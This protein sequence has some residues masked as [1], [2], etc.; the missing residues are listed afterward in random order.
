M[1]HI[2]DQKELLG[3]FFTEVGAGGAGEIE[4]FE[5]DLQDAVEVSGAVVAFEDV[6]CNFGGFEG[7]F[8][9]SID[10]FCGGHEDAV[11]T[12]ELA[13]FE[14]CFCFSG[15]GVEVF[16][17][18]ELGGV[19]EDGDDGFVVFPDALFDEGDV[20]FMKCAHGGDE[21]DGFMMYAFSVLLEFL[22][23]GDLYH[24]KVSFV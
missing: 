5:D 16:A 22:R 4:E 18:E 6:S 13:D 10:S 3:I 7:G 20:S 12:G 14:V 2:L 8:F 15:V 9:L 21:A 24:L 19:D 23:C 1:Y 11:H 17:G